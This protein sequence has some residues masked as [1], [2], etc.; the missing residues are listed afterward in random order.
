MGGIGG[1]GGCHQDFFDVSVIYLFSAGAAHRIDAPEA[2]S[3]FTEGA[4][5]MEDGG[6]GRG[7]QGMMSRLGGGSRVGRVGNSQSW[8][9][10]VKFLESMTR[11]RRRLR[12]AQPDSLSIQ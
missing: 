4:A 11:Q 2:S 12:S 10:R 6:G 5:G 3:Y 9:K 1:G 7:E 8:E